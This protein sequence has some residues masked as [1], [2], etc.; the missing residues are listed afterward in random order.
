MSSL[1]WWGGGS[2][3]AIEPHAGEKDLRPSGLAARAVQQAEASI[4]VP[5]R[6]GDQRKMLSPV[7]AGNAADVVFLLVSARQSVE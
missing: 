3:C 6:N 1:S 7:E 4:A 5:R 2:G